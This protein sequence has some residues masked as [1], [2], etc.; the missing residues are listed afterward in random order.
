[1]MFAGFSMVTLTAF[2]FQIWV[3]ALFIRA[4][5][6]DP[7]QVGLGMGLMQLI[8]GTS[9]VYFGGWLSDRLAARGRLDAQL[10]VAAFGFV[11][12]GAL[13]ALAPLMPTGGLALALLA[14]ALFLSNIP[15]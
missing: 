8:F 13:G 11:G 5:G 15:F 1:P 9:G 7:A 4:Y 10:K 12:C 14:P 3:P 2:A 6:W